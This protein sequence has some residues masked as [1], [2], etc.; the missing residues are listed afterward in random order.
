MN[1]ERI[2]KVLNVKGRCP[3]G[4]LRLRWE[5]QVRNDVMWRGE[6]IG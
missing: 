5:E 3:G 4:A 1:G 2:P 6:D